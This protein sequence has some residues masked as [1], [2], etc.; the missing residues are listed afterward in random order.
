M[1][2][3]VDAGTSRAGAVWGAQGVWNIYLRNKGEKML[4]LQNVSPL[5]QDPSRKEGC[6]PPSFY[7]PSPF[8][9]E[10]SYLEPQRFLEMNSNPHSVA[11]ANWSPERVIYLSGPQGRV[12]QRSRVWFGQGLR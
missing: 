11:G 10:K 1:R 12:R 2:S 3:S 9:S 7:P 6:G 4:Q 8:S 5:C